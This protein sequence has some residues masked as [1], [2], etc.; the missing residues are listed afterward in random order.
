MAEGHR[1]EPVALG[2]RLGT[3]LQAAMEGRWAEQKL[4]LIWSL[5]RALC[6]PQLHLGSWDLEVFSEDVET[7]LLGAKY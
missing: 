6:L 5:E 2:S 4:L 1:E 3:E 7:R